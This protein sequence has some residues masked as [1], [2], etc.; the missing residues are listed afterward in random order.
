MPGW[1]C[2][3]GA[4]VP[5]S[6]RCTY[7]RSS[8]YPNGEPAANLFLG[9]FNYGG[10][11]DGTRHLFS[12]HPCW[13]GSR[14]RGWP[15]PSSF[16]WEPGRRA[17]GVFLSMFVAMSASRASLRGRPYGWRVVVRR[18][19]LYVVVPAVWPML[20]FVGRVPHLRRGETSAP[21]AACE[22]RGGPVNVI[23]NWPRPTTKRWHLVISSSV[24]RQR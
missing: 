13:S 8:S 14:T 21:M 4:G 20:V 24:R 6:W 5:F 16:S 19:R 10:V 1:S 2:G 11:L 17:D 3:C 22:L 7:C 15:S 18:V 9:F 12:A 23:H